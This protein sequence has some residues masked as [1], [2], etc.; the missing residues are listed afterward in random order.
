VRLERGQRAVAAGF[1][2]TCS[3]CGSAAHSPE[4]VHGGE[5]EA[6]G[7]VEIGRNGRGRSLNNAQKVHRL[8]RR[9]EQASRRP[10]VSAVR[11][12]GASA[13]V[14]RPNSHHRWAEAALHNLAITL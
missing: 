8:E 11:T 1:L 14:E 6:L 10:S 7:T 13:L 9:P 5:V 3:D 12:R 4:E 2:S